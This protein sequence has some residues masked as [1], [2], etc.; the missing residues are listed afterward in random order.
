MV[1]AARSLATSG[2]AIMM[3]H[4]T[5]GLVFVVV[6]LFYTTSLLQLHVRFRQL[7]RLAW[8][9]AVMK[10]AKLLIKAATSSNG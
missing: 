5:K 10:S 3:V 9:S 2:A 1:E 4:L 6:A 8:T 7:R